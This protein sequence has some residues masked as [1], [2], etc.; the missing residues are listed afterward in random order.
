MPERAVLAQGADEARIVTFLQEK[1]LEVAAVVRAL[2]VSEF[3]PQ[4][5]APLGVEQRRDGRVLAVV[6]GPE[7]RRLRVE[8][9]VARVSELRKEEPRLAL[10]ADGRRE[11]RKERN[12][13]NVLH[14]ERGAGAVEV[15]VQVGRGAVEVKRPGGRVVLTRREHALANAVDALAEPLHRLAGDVVVRLGPRIG[16][17]DDA[18]A[19]PEV[20]FDALPGELVLAVVEDH[21]PLGDRLAGRT[22]ELHPVGHEP[23]APPGDLH[24][25]RRDHAVVGADLLQ[26]VGHDGD[27]TAG[28]PDRH[29]CRRRRRLRRRGTAERREE[30]RRR[31][32]D[33]PPR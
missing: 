28:G 4:A 19:G 8:A 31:Q 14:P 3:G 29:R 9:L 23:R 6:D 32:H 2:D 18:G 16:L 11:E 21:T 10:A 1:A 26:L 17:I 24:V 20:V 5:G 30:R 27:V 33:A 15:V 22:I 7:E 12:E 25:A 13:R